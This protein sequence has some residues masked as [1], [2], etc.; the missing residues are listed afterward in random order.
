[1]ADENNG[2]AKGLMIGFV[3]GA[4]AGAV[5]AL[6]Y[7]PKSGKELRR[8]IK[9]KAGDIKDSPTIAAFGII[10]AQSLLEN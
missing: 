1:M 7:A 3:A 8:D 4:V 9:E 2:M 6:L 10:I 5:V